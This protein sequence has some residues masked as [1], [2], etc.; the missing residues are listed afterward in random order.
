[1][2]LPPTTS[3]IVLPASARGL[4]HP[5]RFLTDHNNNGDAIFSSAFT[6]YIPFEQVPGDAVF[7]L[8]YATNEHP[9]TLSR[10]ADIKVYSRTSPHLKKNVG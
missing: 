2:A 10:G 7:S 5:K 4:S 6:E 1:M 8:C 9:V 3:T